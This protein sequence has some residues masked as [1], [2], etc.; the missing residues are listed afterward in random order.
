MR[1]HFHA[2]RQVAGGDLV[3]VLAGFHQ[4]A[5]DQ[6]AEQDAAENHQQQ[7]QAHRNGHG[8][9]GAVEVC[10]GLIDGGLLLIAD[11]LAEVA[12]GLDEGGATRR[13]VFVVHHVERRIVFAAQGFHH[14]VHTVVDVGTIAT[15]QVHRQLAAGVV[16]KH[17]LLKV[18]EAAAHARQQVRGGLQGGGRVAG[19]IL[20][21]A[22]A[23]FLQVARGHHQAHA[24]AQHV[25]VDHFDLLGTLGQR[26]HFAD[27]FVI[28]L[29]EKCG[30]AAYRRDQDREE[31]HHPQQHRTDAGVTQPQLA[32]YL[33]RARGLLPAFA[34]LC[35]GFE[36]RFHIFPHPSGTALTK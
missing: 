21:A 10:F 12:D 25:A 4:R 11:V 14:R 17:V 34:G 1:L 26:V 22:P 24:G 13:A 2:A 6:A 15:H 19:R 20:A 3:E 28:V 30:Q 5:H 29:Q 32:F 8:H 23:G 7:R 9:H 16:L 33:G 31:R 27:G 18:R 35:A 36:T